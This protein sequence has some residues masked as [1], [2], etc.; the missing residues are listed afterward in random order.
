[1]KSNKGDE[2]E[3]KME[4]KK[5]EKSE[6]EHEKERG[7]TQSE[8]DKRKERSMAA[9]EGGR[10]SSLLSD[11][12]EEGERGN[13]IGCVSGQ[14]QGTKPKKKVRFSPEAVILSASL[15]GELE[16]V[17]DCVHEVRERI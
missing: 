3:R 16:T 2:G 9:M 4:R 5:E 1:M 8:E 11:M 12:G 6:N 7:K 10:G 17:Q 13:G 15:E 14:R